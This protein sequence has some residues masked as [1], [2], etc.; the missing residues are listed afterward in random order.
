MAQQKIARMKR[1][2]LEAG[3]VTRD[4]EPMDDLI[5]QELDWTDRREFAAK[6][7]IGGLR[8]LRKNE[9]NAVVSRRFGM[10]PEHTDYAI[11]Q[12]D[13]KTGKHAAHFG[14]Q[15]GERFQNERVRSLQ[16]WFGR[17]RHGLYG[18]SERTK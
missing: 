15:G 18:L 2:H 6:F 5:S 13:G 4:D 16:F 17:A 7:W 11:A 9:P 10:I 8:A 1:L 3:T 14:A 12:V